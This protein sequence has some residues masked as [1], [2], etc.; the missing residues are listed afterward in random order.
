MANLSRGNALPAPA[1]TTRKRNKTAKITPRQRKEAGEGKLNKHWRTY[2]LQA[3]AATSNVRLASETTGISPSRAYKARREEAA[4][5]LQWR[6]ALLEGY[7]H[8]E[9]E[10]LGHLRDPA[11][12]RKLDVAAALRLLAAHRETVERQ[13]AL[14]SEEDEQATVE[15]L[16]AFFEGL[17]QRRLAN[18]RLLAAP[19]GDDEDR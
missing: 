14:E 13:R 19:D 6:E 16:D 5:A 18:E 17:R 8:L 12:T 15:A 2:F 7:D 10:I 11:P 9:L 1:T 3:L 4:F